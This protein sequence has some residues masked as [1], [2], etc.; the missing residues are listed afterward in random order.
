MKF[1][2]LITFYLTSAVVLIFSL[3]GLPFKYFKFRFFVLLFTRSMTAVLRLFK[4]NIEVVNADFAHK[5]GC[6]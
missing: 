4:I 3:V 6:L 2:F 5:K 1:S